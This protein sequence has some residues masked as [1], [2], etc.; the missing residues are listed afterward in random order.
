MFGETKN[1]SF[2]EFTFHNVSINT[3]APH[4][5]T[6]RLMI[7]TFHNVSIN[8]NDLINIEQKNTY[9]HSTMFLLIPVQ[10][11]DYGYNCVIYIP[12]CFY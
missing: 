8:T 7:F 12:Q 6:Q 4:I 1:R 10:R 3:V 2:S 5:R 11:A 9:L